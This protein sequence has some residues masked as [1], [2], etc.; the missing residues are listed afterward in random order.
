[1]VGTYRVGRA[2]IAGRWRCCVRGAPWW[3]VASPAPPPGGAPWAT[4]P[5]TPRSAPTPP[6]A[7]TGPA[8]P[9]PASTRLTCTYLLHPYL[10]YIARFW[11]VLLNNNSPSQ[12][13]VFLSLGTGRSATSSLP[14]LDMS[15]LA[16]LWMRHRW[17]TTFLVPDNIKK[18]RLC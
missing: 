17:T 2:C 7:G 6:C 13:F 11:L 18:I 12:W 4:A 10:H 16:S 5:P 3:S 15:I 8:A 1:M 9:T 14:S